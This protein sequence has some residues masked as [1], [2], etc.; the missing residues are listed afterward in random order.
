MHFHEHVF[1]ESWELFVSF[2]LLANKSFPNKRVLNDFNQP[3]CNL[4]C[5]SLML[6]CA[7]LRANFPSMARTA[8]VHHESSVHKL[9]IV[10]M[11]C[12]ELCLKSFHP[13][14]RPGLFSLVA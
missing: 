8:H 6:I 3:L 13:P 7:C 10:D 4:C 11:L 1:D 12:A 2:Y 9:R 14:S 5:T